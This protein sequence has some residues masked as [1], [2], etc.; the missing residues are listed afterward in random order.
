MSQTLIVRGLALCLAQLGSSGRALPHSSPSRR[1]QVHSIRKTAAEYARGW[2]VCDLLAVFPFDMV[3]GGRPETIRLLLCAKL[4]KMSL[5]C[6][7]IVIFFARFVHITKERRA[8]L[9]MV[10]LLLF[11]LVASHWAA[12]VWWCSHA[13]SE[14]EHMHC[15]PKASA[16]V[17]VQ[18]LAAGAS[19]LCARARGVR[20]AVR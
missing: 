1:L 3:L 9:V 19:G 7:P 11:V 5:L 13:I 15:L 2:F 12:C 4:A 18:V 8:L 10:Q 6:A 20:R 16:F 17:G 14:P